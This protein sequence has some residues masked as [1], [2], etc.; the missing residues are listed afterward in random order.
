[1]QIECL[2]AHVK[3]GDRNYPI[4][5]GFAPAREVARVAVAPAFSRNT[6]NQQIAENVRDEP[7]RDWQ[8]PLNQERVARISE[9]FNSTGNLMPNPVL[10]AKNAFA[11]G[12]TITPNTIDGLAYAT[13]TYIVEIT[14]EERSEFQR[15]LWILDGQHRIAGLSASPQAEDPVPVVLLL[16]DGSGSYSSPLLA[17]LFAQVTTSATKLDP[18]HD[19][20]LTYAF[21]LGK[22]D[23]TSQ[24]HV[25][26]HKAFDTV[27]ELCRNPT[28]GAIDNPFFS[29][30]QFNESQSASPRYGGF[31][32]ECNRLSELISKA[33]Y[34]TPGEVEHEDPE[35]VAAELSKAYIALHQVTKNHSSSVFFGAPA[36]QQAILQEAFFLGV[37]SRTLK[38]GATAD[39]K[40]V[41]EGLNFQG[42]NWDFSWVVSLSG[43]PNSISKTIA[44]AVFDEA[45]TSGKLPTAS[46]NLADHLR[47]NN[48]SVTLVFSP[49]SA[50]GRPVRGGKSY[51]KA[52]RGSTGSHPAS[53]TPHVKLVAKTSNVGE[54][55]IYE[56]SRIGRQQRHRSIERRGIN[57]EE[58][59]ANPLQLVIQMEHYGGTSSHADVEIQW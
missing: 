39:W 38:H 1:M 25:E 31:T 18:L 7:V 16:D 29:Q 52:L 59:W 14:D 54:A 42:T 9:I 27:V 3:S 4:Y 6:A 34:R 8:R 58:P 13:G 35:A 30:V 26:S 44:R 15:P 23:I 53:A 41:L 46:T 36:K 57:L 37:L 20:W 17:S 24:F 49:V 51:Y 11:D 33:Y 56:A 28:L 50:S 48:A 40:A 19:E 22:Y 12:V 47:G 21:R 10:L 32:F 2:R 45:L 43:R 55:M 5:V